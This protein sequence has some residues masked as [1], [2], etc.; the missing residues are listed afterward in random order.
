MPNTLR[1][2]EIGMFSLTPARMDI[3]APPLIHPWLSV[4]PGKH[5]QRQFVR[6]VDRSARPSVPFLHPQSRRA[7]SAQGPLCRWCLVHVLTRATTPMCCPW[8]TFI[9]PVGHASCLFRAE[10]SHAASLAN[11]PMLPRTCLD[12]A[13]RNTPKFWTIF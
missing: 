4:C 2:A 7:A 9:Q 1:C 3:V 13:A 8:A 12:E 11:R 6:I 10:R 5:V